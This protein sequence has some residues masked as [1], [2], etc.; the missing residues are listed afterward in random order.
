MTPR[1]RTLADLPASLAG[2]RALV[3]FDWNVPLA[4]DGS[5]GDDYRIRQSLETI[6]A[7]QS[8]G[9]TVAA[10]SH[11][12]RDGESLAPVVVALE[13][14]GVPAFLA[15]DAASPDAPAT[16]SGAG[17]RIALFENLRRN[18]GEESNDPAFA[19]KL[20]KL[21]DIYVNEAFPVSHRA[22]ASVDAL[23]RLLPSYAGAQFAREVA[24]LSKAFQPKRP[25]TFILG[26]AKF[27]TKIPLLRRFQSADRIFLGGALLNDILRARG[28]GVGISLVSKNPPNDLA[29]IAAWPN[30]VTPAKVVV[31]SPR[32]KRESAVDEVAPYEKIVDV[33]P[34][35][36]EKVV[37]GAASVLWNGPLGL[38][39]EGFSAGTEAAA[40]AVVASGAESI[41]G[42]GDT[43]AAIERANLQD[44]FSFI[45]TAGGAM[46]EFLAAETLPGIEALAASPSV[47]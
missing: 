2:K 19:A 43:I 32:G 28:I 46:L 42:G 17:G 20:A 31:T 8:R 9:A 14:A 18:S 38:F 29:E 30:L 4:E 22:H 25:F 23:P 47:S 5:V 39:E 41:V 26:G 13:E 40:R 10:I 45:S 3:R 21:G 34:S 1:F 16:V 33:A 35:E 11:L 37:G 24:A 44:S 6:R 27:D 15:G 7:L 12:G 36:A